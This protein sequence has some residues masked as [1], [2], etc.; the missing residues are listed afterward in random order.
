LFTLENHKEVLFSEGIDK[1]FEFSSIKFSSLNF[2]YSEK[3]V[4]SDLS[5]IIKRG[6]KVF[7]SGKSGSGKSTFIDIF[8]GF[9]SPVSGNIMINDNLDFYTVLHEWKNKIAYIP[10]KIHIINGSFIENITYSN[11]I[12]NCNMDKCIYISKLCGLHDIILK[13]KDEYGHQI[14]ADFNNL[15][16]GQLKRLAIARAL[17][18]EKSILIL[19]EATSG[20]D[21]ESELEIISILN[22]LGADITI[23][24]VS[25]NHV[26]TDKFSKVMKF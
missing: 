5:Y 9:L 8:C 17:Y 11:S 20:L 23:L 14:N 6:D 18:S 16:G 1:K 22:N 21:Y 15:S 25:H 19:D 3:N 12:E 4:I 7:L 10:Q 13:N 24:F 26:F 2:Y